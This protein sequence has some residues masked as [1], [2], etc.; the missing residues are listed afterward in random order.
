[1]CRLFVCKSYHQ[2]WAARVIALLKTSIVGVN[3]N[4]LLGE[5]VMPLAN[6]GS[7]SLGGEGLVPRGSCIGRI[8]LRLESL[9]TRE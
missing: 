3:A 6:I 9:V 1:M 2:W 7:V 8:V 4:A 5:R